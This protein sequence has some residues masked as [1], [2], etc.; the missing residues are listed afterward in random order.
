MS[1]SNSASLN[2]TVQAH[3]PDQPERVMVWDPFVRLF[4]WS[5]VLAFS[6]AYITEDELLNL[7]AWAGYAVLGLIAARL[8]WGI[9]GTRHARFTDF[10]RG[11]K[12]TLAY[13]KDAL[14]GRAARY[15]GHNPAGAAMVIALI[16][17]L[18]ATALSG[19]AVMGA[20][21]FSGPLAPFLMDL[22]PETAHTLEEIHETVANLTLLLIPL[23]LL[24]VAVSSF[25]HRENLVRSMID[26]FK[27][28]ERS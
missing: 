6:I 23:H 19:M 1:Q 17:G 7:H 8:V 10:V 26:G 28:V 4:H 3:T 21:E 9:V 14:R 24:G 13:I 22:S 2:P 25:Q 27:R 18:L 11:P 16:I 5:L 15:L 20:A 12:N